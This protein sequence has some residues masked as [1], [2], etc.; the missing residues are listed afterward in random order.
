[1]TDGETRGVVVAH[2]EMAQGMVTAVRRIAGTPQDVLRPVSNEGRGP[3]E[4]RDAILEVI[5][6][7]PAVVF[8]DLGAGSCTLAARISCRDRSRVAVVTG[9]N[10]PMLLEFVFHREMGL[11]ELLPRLEEKARSGI[12]ILGAD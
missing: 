7:G 6:E 3:D 9:V 1:M 4:L 12:R 5:G 11:E 8:T 2:G 10:L